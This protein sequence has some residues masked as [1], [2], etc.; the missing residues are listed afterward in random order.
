MLHGGRQSHDIASSPPELDNNSHQASH[1]EE[2]LSRI[3]LVYEKGLTKICLAV[4]GLKASTRIDTHPFK[5]TGRKKR[6][7]F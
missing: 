1:V 6:S 2:E 3:P 7:Q 5:A 4:E